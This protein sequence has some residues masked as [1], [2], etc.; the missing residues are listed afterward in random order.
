[1][2][3][4][5]AEVGSENRK[6]EREIGQHGI[7]NINENGELFADFCAVNRLVIGRTLSTYKLPQDY[8]G[9]TSWKYRKSNRP[10]CHISRR[11]SLQDA[12]NKRGADAASDHHLLTA[13]NYQFTGKGQ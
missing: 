10:H 3:D 12:R 11:S 13:T 5:N 7:G 2:G 8:M 6:G 4:L 1:M 9:V